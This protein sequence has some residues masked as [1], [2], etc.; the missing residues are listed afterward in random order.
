VESG[1][2]ETGVKADLCGLWKFGEG[3]LT[4]R[5]LPPLKFAGRPLI[6]NKPCGRGFIDGNCAEHWPASNPEPNLLGNMKEVRGSNTL[7]GA[8]LLARRI[9]GLARWGGGGGVRNHSFDAGLPESIS[10]GRQLESHRRRHQRCAAG[11]IS[12][13]V[14][15]VICGVLPDGHSDTRLLINCVGMHTTRL[16]NLLP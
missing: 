5:R 6:R 8:N 13:G 15:S 9:A 7:M 12:H 2:E 1:G 4:G 10:A 3:R 11:F 16:G 14:V